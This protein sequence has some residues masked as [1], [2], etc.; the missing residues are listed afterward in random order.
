ML[1]GCGAWATWGC[2]L[3]LQQCSI[4][5]S[6][7]HTGSIDYVSLVTYAV[8]LTVW[9]IYRQGGCTYDLVDLVAKSKYGT[10]W[11]R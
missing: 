5:F 4:E 7:R 11:L 2:V 3:Q 9:V 8:L 1:D 6:T 10:G